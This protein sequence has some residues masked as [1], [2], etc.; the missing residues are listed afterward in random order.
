LICSDLLLKTC[1]N[2]PGFSLGSFTENTD[3]Q[4]FMQMRF[5]YFW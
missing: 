5:G 4:Y 1:L 3:I 2:L